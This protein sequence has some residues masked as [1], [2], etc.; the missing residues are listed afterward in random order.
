MY[1]PGSHQDGVYRTVGRTVPVELVSFSADVDNNNALLRWITASEINNR[2]FDVERKVI[3]NRS[4]VIRGWE[5]IG[6]V[7]GFGTTTENKAYSFVNE[8][9]SNRTYIYRL[10]QIDF[11]GS[12]EYSDILE[13]EVRI[14]SEFFLSQNYPNPFNPST[15]IS[16]SIKDAGVVQII[17][18]DILG[19]KVATLVNEQKQAGAFSVEFDASKLPSG[20]YF[21]QLKTGGFIDIK[22]MI[23]L[24]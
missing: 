6:F 7:A 24:K 19:N 9:V 8:N 1:G 4:S 20:I 5:K 11:D 2:G 12:Y 14:L 15:T 21:Y 23:L 13:V 18:Y 17:I 22:K 16:Y 3:D 10:K